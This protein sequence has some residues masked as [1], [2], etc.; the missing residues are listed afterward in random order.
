MSPADSLVARIRAGEPL[1]GAKLGS[2]DLSNRNLSGA[3]LAG[4]V[5]LGVRLDEA[6]HSPIPEQDE[7]HQATTSGTMSGSRQ[8]RA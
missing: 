6:A 8:K 3:K 1:E 4:A 2:L 7:A 5:L